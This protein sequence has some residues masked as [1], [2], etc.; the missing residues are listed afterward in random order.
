MDGIP[1]DPAIPRAEPLAHSA[2]SPPALGMDVTAENFDEAVEDLRAYLPKVRRLFP[3]CA[4]FQQRPLCHRHS[5]VSLSPSPQAAFVSIDEEMTGISLTQRDPISWD[6]V[7]ADRYE[8]MRH[9]A[10]RFAVIQFGI[11]LFLPS[12]SGCASACAPAR[13]ATR[14]LALPR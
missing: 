4:H 13:P 9:V 2:A 3:I 11:A 14:L 1:R 6:E 12:V 8:R 5:H 10:G 7:P